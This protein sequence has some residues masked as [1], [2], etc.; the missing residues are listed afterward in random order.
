MSRSLTVTVFGLLEAVVEETV[1]V[2]FDVPGSVPG[3]VLKLKV[4]SV[5][6]PAVIPLPETG[7]ATTHWALVVT[8]ISRS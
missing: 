8:V 7:E 6:L 2:A 1:T 4:M 5:P 3:M